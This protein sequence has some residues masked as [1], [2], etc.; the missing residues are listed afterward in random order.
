M[1]PPPPP[2]DSMTFT[3]GVLLSPS[4]VTDIW[5]VSSGI[6]GNAVPSYDWYHQSTVAASGTFTNF[7]VL[8]DFAVTVPDF[9]I[10][11]YV[12]GVA[13]ALS[14]D[15]STGSSGAADLTHSVHVD[16]GDFLTFVLESTGDTGSAI[17]AIRFTE[18]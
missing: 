9:I 13:T 7:Y 5:P 3:Q 12:N 1:A 2:S 15:Q 6:T 14:V 11:L 18:D 16:A 8:Q 4:A 17:L 10:T